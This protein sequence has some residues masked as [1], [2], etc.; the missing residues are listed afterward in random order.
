MGAM[1]GP[2]GTEGDLLRLADLRHLAAPLEPDADGRRRLTELAVAHVEAFLA[3]ASSAPTLLPGHGIADALAAYGVP[4]TPRQAAEVL[5]IVGRL[6][7]SPG[8]A[9][10]SP[11]YFGYIPSGGLYS[12][13]IADFLAAASNRYS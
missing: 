10:T 7:E 4:E 6:V 13:A 9:T 11:R 1:T 5:D 12:A 2:G 8:V 3:E